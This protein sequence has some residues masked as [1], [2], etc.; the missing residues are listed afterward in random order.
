[1]WL[2]FPVNAFLIETSKVHVDFEVSTWPHVFSGVILEVK[3]MHWQRYA[4]WEK[5]KAKDK[6]KMANWFKQSDMFETKE[7]DLNR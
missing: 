7:N 2:Q 1:M 5:E 4:I 6:M 3:L